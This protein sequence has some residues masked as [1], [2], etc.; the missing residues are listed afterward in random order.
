[1]ILNIASKTLM[2]LEEWSSFVNSV[3]AKQHVHE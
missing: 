3:S 2:D 1:M